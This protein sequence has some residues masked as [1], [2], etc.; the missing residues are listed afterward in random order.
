MGGGSLAN[1]PIGS[2]NSG[3]NFRGGAARALELAWNKRPRQGNS[4]ELGGA[5]SIVGLHMIFILDIAHHDQDVHEPASRL[6]W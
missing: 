5:E 1:D 6:L 3:V 2:G 4:A